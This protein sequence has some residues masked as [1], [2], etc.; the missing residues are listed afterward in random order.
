MPLCKI[1]YLL[2]LLEEGGYCLVDR[3]ILSDL[4]PVIQKQEKR[5]A[6]SELEGQNIFIIF[7]AIDHLGEAL[8]L[9]DRF[10]TND[11][12]IQQRLIAPSMLY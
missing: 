3:H 9:V 7:N 10:I 12:S 8:C 1:C 11:W 4:V 5:L 2:D 6:F